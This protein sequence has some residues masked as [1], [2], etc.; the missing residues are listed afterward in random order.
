MR[1]EERRIGEDWSEP[2]GGGGEGTSQ[3]D[4]G[5]LGR[6]GQEAMCDQEVCNMHKR[7]PRLVDMTRYGRSQYGST[8][9][10]NCAAGCYWLW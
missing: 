3:S 5:G 9:D 7:V 6:V 10:N 1:G 8:R 4:E 2:S